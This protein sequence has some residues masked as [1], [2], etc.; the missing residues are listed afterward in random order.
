MFREKYED[1]DYQKLLLREQ[2]TSDNGDLTEP[3]D[4]HIWRLGIEVHGSV[5]II[6]I[7]FSSRYGFVIWV[8]VC[9]LLICR[10]NLIE[11]RWAKLQMTEKFVAWMSS[12]FS[13]NQNLGLLEFKMMAL[14]QILAT[15]VPSKHMYI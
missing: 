12:C 8:E 1:E 4:G 9:R 5:I 7:I 10:K 2:R 3:Y 6:I 15:N 13:Q 11:D 14:S